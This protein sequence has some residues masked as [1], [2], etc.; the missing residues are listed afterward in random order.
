MFEHFD[1]PRQLLE[2]RIGS[3]ISME[4]DSLSMLG[5]LE[6]AAQSEDI[7]EMFR[8]HADETRHQMQNLDQ[9]C[10]ELEISAAEEPSQTTKGL[11]REGTSLIRKSD[12]SLLDSVVLSAA[13]ETEHTEIAAYQSLIC[14]ADSLRLQQVVE[15]LTEN[16]GQEQHTS[17]ELYD[18]LKSIVAAV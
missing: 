11:S 3:A 10:Q 7:K 13:L 5:E 6:Q 1:N 2:Y 9:V 8:H 17:E 16:L 14:L 18:K 4:Q 15:L 12:V